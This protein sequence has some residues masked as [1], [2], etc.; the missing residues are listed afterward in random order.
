MNARTRLAASIVLGLAA[1][2]PVLVFTPWQV[3][4]LVP[5][6]GTSPTLP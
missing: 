1:I 3:G 4:V 5:I 2:A 6:L